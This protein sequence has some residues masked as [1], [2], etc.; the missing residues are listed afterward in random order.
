MLTLSLALFSL[1]TDIYGGPLLSH[2]QLLSE[3]SPAHATRTL[4]LCLPLLSV[5]IRS[6]EVSLVMLEDSPMSSNFSN[7]S[8]VDTSDGQTSQNHSIFT[9]SPS[10]PSGS[11]QSSSRSGTTRE[12]R[13]MATTTTKADRAT[14]QERAESRTR[15]RTN[16]ILKQQLPTARRIRCNEIIISFFLEFTMDIQY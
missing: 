12:W 11:S 8:K 13:R 16:S 5:P 3:S 7:S 10:S 14:N 4:E 2:A 1:R 15:M 6:P 9:S